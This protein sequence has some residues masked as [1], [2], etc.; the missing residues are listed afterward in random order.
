MITTMSTTRSL[1][2]LLLAV[3]MIVAVAA[4]VHAGVSST[5]AVTASYYYL[6]DTY[7]VFAGPAF[8]VEVGCQP[9]DDPEAHVVRATE[10]VVNQQG[11]RTE[12][13]RIYRLADY[14]AS[15]PLDVLIGICVLGAPDMPVAVGEGTVWFNNQCDPGANGCGAPGSSWEAKNGVRAELE[16]VETGQ[17][18]TVR[19]FAKV[20][21]EVPLDG[22]PVET[23]L[24]DIV[25]IG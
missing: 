5:E 20:S 4:P 22:P 23:L 3:A 17:P 2:A 11:R 6:D 10:D 7:A 25:D 14:D 24:V 8:D 9:G 18:V 19:T 13:V 16:D 1:A 21:V 12:D 15:H